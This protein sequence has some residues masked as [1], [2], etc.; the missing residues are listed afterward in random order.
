MPHAPGYGKAPISPVFIGRLPVRI[1][2]SAKGTSGN[3][4]KQPSAL[5]RVWHN[6]SPTVLLLDWFVL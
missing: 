1:A 4:K 6:A 3:C 5:S 2:T